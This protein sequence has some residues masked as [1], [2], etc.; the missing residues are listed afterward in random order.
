MLTFG[1]VGCHNN[2]KV[3]K[4]ITLTTG[5]VTTTRGSGKGQNELT[6]QLTDMVREMDERSCR[7]DDQFEKILSKVSFIN[8]SSFKRLLI[9]FRF[10]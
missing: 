3:I 8:I 2:K 10:I 7:H 1:P 5:G 4:F 9:L 6:I